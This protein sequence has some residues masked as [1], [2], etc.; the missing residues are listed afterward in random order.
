[1]TKKA[2][3]KRREIRSDAVLRKQVVKKPLS[4]PKFYT[5]SVR[6]KI[7]NHKHKLGAKHDNEA[8]SK[9]N[10]VDIYSQKLRRRPS[11]RAAA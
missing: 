2:R 5:G 4:Q 7:S 6:R 11:H 8:E 10:L 3:K 9:R 1:M